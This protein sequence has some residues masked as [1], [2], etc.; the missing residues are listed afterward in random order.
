MLSF[1]ES[2]RARRGRKE[3][4]DNEVMQGAKAARKKYREKGM[5]QSHGGERREKRWG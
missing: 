4:S 1:D 3:V 5:S 2:E